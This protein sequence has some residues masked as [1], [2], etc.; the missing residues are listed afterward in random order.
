MEKDADGFRTETIIRKTM[1][2]VCCDCYDSTAMNLLS[3]RTDLSYEY[4]Y[5]L[6]LV[7]DWK[8][9]FIKADRDD[10]ISQWKRNIALLENKQMLSDHFVHDAIA[11]ASAGY[12]DIV[13]FPYGFFSKIVSDIGYKLPQAFIDQIPKAKLILIPISQ[14]VHFSLAVIVFNT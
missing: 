8:L 12:D 5:P 10:Y 13:L 6:H 9:V 7:S 14:G 11:E 4:P 2:I 1:M 3:N